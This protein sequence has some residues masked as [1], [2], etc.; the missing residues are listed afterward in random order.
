MYIAVPSIG[1]ILLF[2]VL[3][4]TFHLLF[5]PLIIKNSFTFL[6]KKVDQAKANTTAGNFSI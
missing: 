5:G 4:M 3:Y 2:F 6:G 1:V